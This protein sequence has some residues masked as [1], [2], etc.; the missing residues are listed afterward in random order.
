MRQDHRW[1]S[2]KKAFLK[3]L[4]NLIKVIVNINLGPGYS[5]NRF[6]LR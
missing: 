6:I 4:L 3:L 2:K 5:N 1:L